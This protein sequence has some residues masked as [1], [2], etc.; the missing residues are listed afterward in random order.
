MRSTAAI[1]CRIVYNGALNG[2]LAIWQW[3][4]YPGRSTLREQRVQAMQGFSKLAPP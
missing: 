4:V 2:E 1:V 3:A